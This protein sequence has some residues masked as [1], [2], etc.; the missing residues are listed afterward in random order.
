MR[1]SLI[2]A[3]LIVVLA[4]AHGARAQSLEDALAAAYAGNPTLQ[5]KRAELRATDEG[6]P[7]ALSDWRPSLSAEA[8]SGYT[9]NYINTRS[10]NQTQQPTPHSTSLT[11]SQPL[12]SGGQTQAA[13]ASAENAV[14]AG[15]AE[16][17]GI[18]Q[19]VL[20]DAVKSYVNVF[21][22]QA[23]LELRVSNEQVLRRQLEATSDRFEVGEITRTD[24]HQ[25]EARLARTTADRIQAEGDLVSN[26]ATYRNVIGSTPE[27]LNRPVMD[28]NLPGD[29]NE[30][31]KLAVAQNPDV[32]S[33]EFDERASREDIKEVRGEL[34]PSLDLAGSASRS[35]NAA[36]ERTRTDSYSA[37]LTLTVPLYQSGSVYSRLRA[38]RQTAS[39]R[40]RQI[41]TARRD[42]TEIATRAWENLQTS[43]ARIL[44]LNAQIKASEVALEGVQR[45]ASVGSRTVL[46]VLDAEQELLDAKVNVV[47]AERDE[48]IAIFELKSAIGELTASHLSLPVEAY[49]S[50]SHYNEVRQ[51]WFGGGIK[52]DEPK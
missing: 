52:N 37:K 9:N 10:S 42:A 32:L 3:G 19:T 12:Y 15:R 27:K 47:S 20:L 50:T 40:R 5:A 46:D 49:D 23:I 35:L 2:L 34:L 33:A 38:A 1:F 36:S 30:S 7:Q 17:A 16:L 6:V 14:L 44:S 18:E 11:L 8:A 4:H 29:A 45:E 41:D 43:R 26:R 39:Q 28:L 31:V 21:R 13:V 51:K 24:V 48:T 22:A 25:A